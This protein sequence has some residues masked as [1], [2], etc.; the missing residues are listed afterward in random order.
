MHCADSPLSGLSRR[1]CAL[2]A[3][4]SALEAGAESGGSARFLIFRRIAQMVVRQFYAPCP[5]PAN[6]DFSQGVN[7][8]GIGNVY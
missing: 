6:S 4:S 1:Q 8:T 7:K 5:L 2:P 3:F